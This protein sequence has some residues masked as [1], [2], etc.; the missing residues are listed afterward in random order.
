MLIFYH[1]PISGTL[2]LPQLNKRC[3]MRS[4]FL[5]FNVQFR[6]TKLTHNSSFFPFNFSLDIWF[7]FFFLHNKSCH[8]SYTPISVPFNLICAYN[9][10]VVFFFHHLV[11]NAFKIYSKK[12]IFLSF[13]SNFFSK[14]FLLFD[15]RHSFLMKSTFSLFSL[16]LFLFWMNFGFEI[17]KKKS[18]I[19]ALT[20]FRIAWEFELQNFLQAL[21]KHLNHLTNPKYKN[22]RKKRIIL[23]GILFVILFR[24]MVQFLILFYF[25]C[26]IELSLKIHFALLVKLCSSVSAQKL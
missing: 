6:Q 17:S 3:D 21:L 18:V 23:I 19:F 25:F 10:S 4:R 5:F 20:I 26:F 12:K 24:W 1:W 15:S 14:Y 16:G 7:S 8:T 9:I 2:C 11:L 22:N 13:N